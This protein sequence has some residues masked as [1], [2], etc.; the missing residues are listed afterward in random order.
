MISKVFV[1]AAGG[2][3]A[4]A[5]VLWRAV[6]DTTRRRDIP[7][8]LLKIAA[9]QWGEDSDQK[10][11]F[12]CF[13]AP[14]SIRNT[15]TT[16]CDGER[17]TLSEDEKKLDGAAMA[18]A[19]FQSPA[20][21][22]ERLLWDTFGASMVKRGV[23][24]YT[25]SEYGFGDLPQSLSMD[26]RYQ[27]WRVVALNEREAVIFFRSPGLLYVARSESGDEVLVGTAIAPKGKR[28]TE[29]WGGALDNPDSW[30]LSLTHHAYTR[31]LAKSTACSI[32]N[33][34]SAKLI[35]SQ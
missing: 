20:F 34:L 15:E 1:A 30:G 35:D 8:T 13:S 26:S 14:Y 29:I 7:P 22:P 5:F 31:F 27:F 2:V 25:E 10:S 19:L 4:F 12:D 16:D 3:G 6:A 24:G 21:Y 28:T 17:V 9:E 23:L 32:R 33:I 18:L 11:Y